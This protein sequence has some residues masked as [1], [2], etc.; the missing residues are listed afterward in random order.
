MIRLFQN[1]A[2]WSIISNGCALEVRGLER[3]PRAPDFFADQADPSSGHDNTPS[4]FQG[5]RSCHPQCRWTCGKSEC[6]ARC[7]PSCKPPMCVIACQKPQLSKC[8]QVCEDPKCAVVCPSNA[9][10]CEARRCPGCQTICGKPNCRTD[11]G[12][13][14]ACRS[15]CGDPACSWQCEPTACPEPNCTLSCSTPKFCGLGGPTPTLREVYAGTAG[16]TLDAHGGHSAENVGREVSWEGL[17]SVPEF[18]LASHAA[19]ALGANAMSGP[20]KAAG[21]VAMPS[22][23][24]LEHPCN[25]RYCSGHSTGV[26]GCTCGV[27]DVGSVRPR[28]RWEK[29]ET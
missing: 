13:R 17:A 26:V 11:C 19:A 6:D 8:K 22:A 28:V 10:F 24:P 29:R 2:L 5:E 9:S 18:Q 21:A 3:W 12:Q 7:T 14:R 1:V 27:K 25:P 20:L 23:L 16:G 15:T 4:I